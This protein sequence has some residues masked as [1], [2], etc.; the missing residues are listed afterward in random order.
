MKRRTKRD[1]GV[2][3]GVMFLIGGVVFANTQL[4]RGNLAE[5]YEALRVSLESGHLEE[6]MNLLQWNV[7]R[8]TKGTLRGGGKYT[9]DLREYDAQP[10]HM[11]GFM[12]PLEE[13]RDVTQFL[14]LPIPIECYFCS[15]PPTRDV[16]FV[17]LQEG[18]TAQI[19]SEPVLVLGNFTINQGPDQQFF[20]TLEDAT[21]KA[22][23]DSG[24]L[25]RRKLELQHML[26]NHERDPDMLLDPVYS[27]DR[28]D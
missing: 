17:Q 8:T 16:L 25:T 24:E 5:K 20:Y 3:V 18:E 9:E 6:G 4:R 12:V 14:M 23:E 10:V 22:A 28:T 26:P 2:L 15:M 27:D 11:I 19:Y 1:L 7:V 13:F 21:I